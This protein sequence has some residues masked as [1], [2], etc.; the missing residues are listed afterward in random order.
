MRSREVVRHEYVHAL[1]RHHAWSLP[2]WFE[3]GLAE[4]L[5]NNRDAQAAE[6][7]LKEFVKAEPQV[8][9][10]RFALAR[11]YEARRDWSKALEQLGQID[12]LEDQRATRTYLM[13]QCLQTRRHLGLAEVQAEALEQEVAD[14]PG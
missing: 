12:S 4:F 3:E 5:A 13:E 6:D 14:A 1:V 2:A 10:F 8:Y 9:Q 11:L 7:T